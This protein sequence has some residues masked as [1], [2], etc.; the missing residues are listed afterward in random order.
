MKSKKKIKKRKYLKVKI[1]N[2]YSEIN[3]KKNKKCLIFVIIFIGFF[4]LTLLIYKLFINKEASIPFIKPEEKEE[5]KEK[6][7]FD[8]YEVDKFNSIKEKLLKYDCSH[9]WDNQREF[10]NGLVRKFKPKKVL[11]VGVHR[12]GSSIIIL[13]AIDDI[14]DSKLYSIDINPEEIVGEC[15]NKYFQNLS[16]KYS[17]FKGNIASAFMEQI[18]NDIDMA[19]F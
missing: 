6:F 5:L 12:G 11:E 10:L 15:V 8:K 14:E 2:S 19:F 17:L 4:I 9:M 7:Y 3:A 18:G 13:N 16:K 1:D